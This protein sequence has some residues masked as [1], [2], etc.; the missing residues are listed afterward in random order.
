MS[1][2]ESNSD[3]VKFASSGPTQFS[4]KVCKSPVRAGKSDKMKFKD[5]IRMYKTKMMLGNKEVDVEVKQTLQYPKSVGLVQYSKRFIQAQMIIQSSLE[6]DSEDEIK[7][8]VVDPKIK[9]IIV[10]QPSNYASKYQCNQACF[11]KCKMDLKSGFVYT[12]MWVDKI[13]G[14]EQD[15]KSAN[16]IAV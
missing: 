11:K 6:F 15:K 3:I 5:A 4:G 1:Y 12:G 8:F 14:K 16:Y 13:D 7:K 10:R 2:Y 9:N